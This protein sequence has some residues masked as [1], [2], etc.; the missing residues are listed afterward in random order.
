MEEKINSKGR[1][2]AKLWHSSTRLSQMCVDHYI[3]VEPQEL[4]IYKKNFNN[5]YVTV[6]P[7]DMKYKAYITKGA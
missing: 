6:I 5:K 1:Y 4:E 2:E 3:V 7:M